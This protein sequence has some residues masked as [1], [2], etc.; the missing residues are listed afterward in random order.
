MHLAAVASLQANY[1]NNLAIYKRGREFELKP[2]EYQIQL[3]VRRNLRAWLKS[4]T[5]GLRVRRANHSATLPPKKGHELR[6]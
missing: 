6:N 3:V 1:S 2:S 5:A 4:L